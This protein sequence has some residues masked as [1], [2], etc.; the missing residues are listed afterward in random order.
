MD[1]LLLISILPVIIIGMYIYNKDKNKE[2]KSLLTKLFIGGIGSCFLVLIL[3]FILGLFF[4]FM[5]SNTQNLST[6]NLILHVFIGVALI[7]EFSK[8]IFTYLISYNHQEFD[9]FYDMILYA[10]FVALGFAAFENILYVCTGGIGTGIARG[11]LAVPGHA[12]DGVFMGYYLG[13][14]KINELNNRPGH[15]NKYLILSILVPTI[16]HGIYDYCLFLGSWIAVLVF[17]AFVIILYI[18]AIRKIK[19]VSSISR[20]IKYKNKFCPK[21]GKTVESNYCPNCGSKNE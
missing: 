13:L 20:K 3:S 18:L 8:W 2:P 19:K 9:E 10:V 7:E 17:F 12:W 16:L 11:I 4:P 14:A 1:I 5:D 21:C 6:V 15:K